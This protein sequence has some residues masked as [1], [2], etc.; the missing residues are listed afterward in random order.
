VNFVDPTGQIIPVIVVG[1]AAY[2][3]RGALSGGGFNFAGQ[4]LGNIRNGRPLSCSNFREV[5]KSSVI[6]AIAPFGGA[7]KQIRTKLLDQ[8]RLNKLTKKAGFKAAGS[9]LGGLGQNFLDFGAN[10]AFKFGLHDITSDPDG[11][12]NFFNFINGI[13][14]NSSDCECP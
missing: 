4:I 1:A 7:S 14:D 11:L 12:P 13:P 3:G 9:H 8:L 5:A 10:F 2:A 6:G